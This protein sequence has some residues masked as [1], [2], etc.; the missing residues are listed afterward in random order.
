MIEILKKLESVASL[1]ELYRS[2]VIN[3]TLIRDR[4]IYYQWD[5]AVKVKGRDKWDALYHVAEDYGLSWMTVLRAI[6]KMNPHAIGE[7]KKSCDSPEGLRQE[8]EAS[9]GEIYGRS[10]ISGCSES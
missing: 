4:E 6:K 10:D 8:S 2:G 3:L 7:S 1:A 5:I 9:S